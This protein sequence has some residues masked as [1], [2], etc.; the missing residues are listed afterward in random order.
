MPFGIESDFHSAPREIKKRIHIRG[1][2]EIVEQHAVTRLPVES[3][4][5]DIQAIAGIHH[6]GDLIGTR[7]V[8]TRRIIVPSGISQGTLSLYGKMIR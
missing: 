1:K 8:H 5:K 2:F 6:E 3:L 7:R 4:C